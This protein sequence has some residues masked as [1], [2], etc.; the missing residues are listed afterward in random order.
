M[1]TTIQPTP[2]APATDTKYLAQLADL[3]KWAV[4]ER[5]QVMTHGTAKANPHVQLAF[6]TA[7]T[8]ICDNWEQ[9]ADE[10]E[11]SLNGVEE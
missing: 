10:L 1:T 7:A 2:P 9:W 5:A 6:V 4:E 3:I 11:H 8:A